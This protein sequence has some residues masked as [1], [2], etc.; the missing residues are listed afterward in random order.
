MRRNINWLVIT[1]SLLL[2]L[3]GCGKES[4]FDESTVVDV[5]KIVSQAEAERILG[6]L[7]EQPK[8]QLHTS[9]VAG[10][11]TWTFK[12]TSGSNSAALYVMLITHGSNGEFQDLDRWFKMSLDEVKV[13]LGAHPWEMKD[14]GDKGFLFQ[15]PQPDHSEIWMRQS[16]TYAVL[17]INGASSSQLDSFARILARELAPKK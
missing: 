13:S 7:I 5:C 17:R 8:P 6:P 9:G 4:R 11:C 10:D 1:L 3:P 15:S 16:K 2:M 14:L 12:S